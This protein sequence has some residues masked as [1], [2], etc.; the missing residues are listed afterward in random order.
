MAMAAVTRNMDNMYPQPP[1]R[2]K[3]LMPEKS[4]MDIYKGKQRV[5]YWARRSRGFCIQEDY[6]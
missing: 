1:I 6:R 2:P 3:L 5:R 4:K